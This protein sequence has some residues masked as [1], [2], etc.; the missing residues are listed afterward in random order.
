MRN[1]ILFFFMCLLSCARQS[2]SP[3]EFSVEDLTYKIKS[4]EFIAVIA[5]YDSLYTDIPAH[6][7][8]GLSISIC[9]TYKDST[10]YEIH[11]ASGITYGLPFIL[12]EPINGKPVRFLTTEANRLFSMKPSKSAKI[13]RHLAPGEYKSYIDALRCDPI[14]TTLFEDIIIEVM[15]HTKWW[16]VVLDNNSNRVIRVDTTGRAGQMIVYTTPE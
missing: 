10:I 5:K 1:L 6:K 13:Q 2:I 9:Q 14:D 8:R 4:D 12:C 11:Y 16:C 7:E 15:M 3:G